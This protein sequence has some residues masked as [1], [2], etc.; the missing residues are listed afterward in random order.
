[1]ALDF[2]RGKRGPPP[3]G[4]RRANRTELPPEYGYLHEHRGVIGDPEQC[5]T[6]LKELEK[7][8]IYETLD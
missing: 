6:K 5:V 1:M 4:C 7:Q 8:G 3:A 2:Q